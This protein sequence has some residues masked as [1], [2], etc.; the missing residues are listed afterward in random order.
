MQDNKGKNVVVELTFDFALKI[1]K[2]AEKLEKDHKYVIAR[3]LLKSGTGIAVNVG[4]CR[5]QKV[6]L[7]SYIS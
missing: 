2:Y 6:N 7:I 5:M 3:Q 1:I 4:R